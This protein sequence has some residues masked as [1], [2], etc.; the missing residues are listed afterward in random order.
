[1]KERA[2]VMLSDSE[3]G[4]SVAASL[5]RRRCRVACYTSLEDLLRE[6]PLGSIPVL[7]FYL[8][9]RPK[10]SLLE[11]IGRL[12]VEYPGIQK[13]AVVEAPLPLEVVEYLTACEV[14]LVGAEPERGPGDLASVVGRMHERRHRSL[15]A[16]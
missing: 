10:G 12:S 6:Q 1:M 4:T 16:S 9:E 2:A 7:I 3:A 5:A 15:A 13:V 11:V 14:D 8:H